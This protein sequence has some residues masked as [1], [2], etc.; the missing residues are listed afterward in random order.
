MLPLT[1]FSD[2]GLERLIS[3][4]EHY[5]ERPF[6]NMSQ[7]PINKEQISATLFHGIFGDLLKALPSF[8]QGSDFS[9]RT[10]QNGYRAGLREFSQ[11]DHQKYG[12]GDREEHP[13]HPPYRSPNRQRNDNHKR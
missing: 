1:R 2:A 10:E 13:R 8:L 12:N 9:I 11:N 6:F 5:W 7:P 3:Y 4:A